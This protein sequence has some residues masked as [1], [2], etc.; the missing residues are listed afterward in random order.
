[1]AQYRHDDGRCS[2][3]GGYVYRGERIPDLA[4]AYVYGDFCDGVVRAFVVDDSG[5]VT[6][7]RAFQVQ[8][9]AL[10]SFGEDV[11]GELYALS[12]EGKVHRLTA[13]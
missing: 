4:G 3:T 7:Q 12:L 6:D 5:R 13:G 9:D 8:V 10:V 11:D 1:V 2:V